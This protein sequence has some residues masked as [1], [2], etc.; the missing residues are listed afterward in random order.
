MIDALTLDDPA[1]PSATAA[2]TAQRTERGCTVTT[3]ADATEPTG[4]LGRRKA[5]TKK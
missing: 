5:H 3:V 4:S 2:F 1:D